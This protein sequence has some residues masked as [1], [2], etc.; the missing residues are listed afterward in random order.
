M[1][2][3]NRTGL[4]DRAAWE[5]AGI[6]LPQFDLEAV[7]DRTRAKPQWVHFGA[8]NIFRAFVANAHQKLLNTGRAD[9]G[10]ITVK[11]YDFEKADKLN[12]LYDNLTLLVLMNAKGEFRK[13]VVGSVAEALVANKARPEDDRRLIEIFENPSLQMVSF[14]ITEK[15]YALTG[16]DGDYLDRVKE[17][18]KNGP[19][20]PVHAMGIAASLAYR[21]YLKG[22]Y[23]LTF[24]SM[25][26]CSHNG[27]KLKNSVVAMAQAWAARGLVEAGFVDYLQDEAKITFPLSMIDKITPRPSEKVQ[28]ILSES[29]LADMELTVTSKHTYTAPFVNAEVS[30][31]LVIEDKFTNGRPPLEEAG[32]IF[33]ERDTV[34]KIET[35][36]VTT[37][38]NPL[39]TALAVTGCLLGYRLI[40]DEMKDPVLR[41]FVEIIGYEEGLPVVVDPGI[42]N[43]R[44]FLDEVLQERFANPYIL[45][46]PQRIATDTSQKVGIRFG[47]TIKAYVRRADLDPAGL[48]AIPLAIA[49]WCRYLLGVDDEGQPFALSP[50]PLLESLQDHLHGVRLGDS[51]APGVRHIL[52]DAR[53][54]GVQLYEIGL[55]EKIEAMFH[56]MLAGPGAVRR[57]LEKY[58]N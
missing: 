9:T 11:T 8:G 45:D 33:T 21:R 6:E 29:G 18:F 7:A 55:G 50:D 39:H 1:L 5:A 26:N 23:P 13:S 17:D 38:L 22:Q 25:D 36:K 42:I 3:L 44:T 57:T 37:C 30:E 35:M 46:T 54:F 31:Y 40:A 43:P 10:I 34:N 51:H 19:E 16:P 20:Q 53:L 58:V 52:E 4:A 28:A 56:E 48:T 2:Q 12:K 47:E 24:V 49:A 41:R 14:T 15:G 32:V 27:D